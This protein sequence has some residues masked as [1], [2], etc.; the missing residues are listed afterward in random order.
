MKRAKFFKTI[1]AILKEYK[2]KEINPSCKGAKEL[3]EMY[4]SFPGYSEKIKKYGIVAWK[5]K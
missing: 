5:L 2:A 3:Q 1:T 4:F